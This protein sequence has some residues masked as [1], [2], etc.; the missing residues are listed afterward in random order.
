MYFIRS[1]NLESVKLLRFWSRQ[2]EKGDANWKRD[3]TERI[4]IFKKNMI[5]KS[6]KKLSFILTLVHPVTTCVSP[7]PLNSSSK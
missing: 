1:K 3:S 5:D 7:C 2:K 4:L 6:N